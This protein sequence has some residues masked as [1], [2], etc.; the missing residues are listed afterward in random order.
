M[1]IY[2]F[3]KNFNV[4][5][6]NQEVIDLNEINE[7]IIDAW[8]YKN[9]DQYGNCLLPNSLIKKLGTKEIEKAIKK[10]TGKKIIIRESYLQN[11]DRKKRD[12]IYVAEFN[13]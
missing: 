13:L 7:T 3:I 9:L 5:F 8:I 12:Q 1:F 4:M 6:P 10:E 11:W 2:F